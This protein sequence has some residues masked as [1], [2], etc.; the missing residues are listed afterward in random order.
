LKL[1]SLTCERKETDLDAGRRRTRLGILK[2][3]G[4]AEPSQ[5]D[6]GRPFFL[7]QRSYHFRAGKQGDDVLI[8][9]NEI[10]HAEFKKE[11]CFGTKQN[12]IDVP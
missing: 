8:K 6:M 5:D 9:K 1:C 4:E 12:R 3:I 10:C 7:R 2:K 11:L